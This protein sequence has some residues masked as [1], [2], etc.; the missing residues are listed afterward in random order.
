MKKRDEIRELR[1]VAK[2]DL[3]KR[4]DDCQEELMRLRFK[5]ASGQ[6]EHTAQF[7]SLRKRIARIKT[8]LRQ[9]QTAA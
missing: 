7:S 6:L 8:I 9:N 1:G 3:L 5:K 2:E 4:A